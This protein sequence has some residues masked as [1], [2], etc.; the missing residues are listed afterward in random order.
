MNTI[1]VAN[2]LKELRG[3]VPVN[4]IAEELGIASSTYRMYELAERMP[5]DKVKIRI[6]EYYNRTV[7]SIFFDFE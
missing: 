2:R 6:A 5:S 4:K 3:D 1:I 7:Q